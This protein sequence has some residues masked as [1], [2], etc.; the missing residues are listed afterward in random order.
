M[1]NTLSL[2]IQNLQYDL[3]FHVT[4]PLKGKGVI[5]DSIMRRCY[6]RR[7]ELHSASIAGDQLDTRT[8]FLQL[9]EK[10]S[11]PFNYQHDCFQRIEFM[12]NYS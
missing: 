8:S 7:S 4:R 5:T 2:Y 1:K 9:L 12:E 3:M 10:F 11:D 6:V